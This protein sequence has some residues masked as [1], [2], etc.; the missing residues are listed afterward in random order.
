MLPPKPCYEPTPS[1]HRPDI[2]SRSPICHAAFGD[3][4]NLWM[5]ARRIAD[6]SGGRRIASDFGSVISKGLFSALIEENNILIFI[7]S[8]YSIMH[9]LDDG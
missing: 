6:K 7:H 4:E 2:S 9:Q 3:V 1:L 5:W 8:N